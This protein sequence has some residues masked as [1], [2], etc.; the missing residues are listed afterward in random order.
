M[1]MDTESN[2]VYSSAEPLDSSAVVCSLWV[3][4]TST[5]PASVW[6]LSLSLQG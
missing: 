2:M 4:D 1:L 3:Q 6:T 5:R